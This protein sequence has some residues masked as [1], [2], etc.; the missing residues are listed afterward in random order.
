MKKIVPLILCFFCSFSAFTQTTVPAGAVSGTWTPA[1][2]PYLIQG[3]ITIP[4]GNVLTIQPGVTVSFQ[5]NF[6]LQ[7]SGRL[8]AVGNG[9][10]S[11]RFT[12]ANTATGWQGIRFD[13]VA[14]ANDSSR[15]AFA[16]IQHGLA[17]L[18]NGAGIYINNSQKI[19][20]Y[21]S[22]IS[23]CTAQAGYGGGIYIASSNCVIRNNTISYNHSYSGGLHIQNANPLVDGNAISYNDDI[24]PSFIGDPGSDPDV[25]A[26]GVYCENS[27][28][29]I[30]NNTITNNI[31]S[32]FGGG[33]TAK[34]SLG[35]LKIIH[36]AISY[37][38]APG[39]GGG[40]FSS[41]YTEIR[42]NVI[43][44][45]QG[46]GISSDG[47][48]LITNNYIGFN[49]GKAVG[50]GITI[51]QSGFTLQP[52]VIDHN[53]IVNNIATNSAGGVYI[54]GTKIFVT[55]NLIANNTV[56]GASSPGNT[57]GG[58][59]MIVINSDSSSLLSNNIISNNTA[60]FGG[61]IRFYNSTTKVYSNTICNNSAENGGG[62][63]FDNSSPT[64][65][66]SLVWGNTA[67]VAGNQ[68]SF[69]DEASDPPVSYS[70]IQG[71]TTAFDTGFF[72]YSGTYQD[73]IDADPLFVSAS[74][75]A[76][77]A[78]DGA[79]ANWAL[80]NG[81]PAINKGKPGVGY[82]ATD[83]AGNTRVLNGIIDMGAL[84]NQTPI[85]PTATVSGGGQVCA[86]G[87]LPAVVF[88]FTYGTFP[89]TL[90]YS[91]NGVAQTPVTGINDLQYTIPHASPGLYT[92]TSITDPFST[93]SGIG[94]ATVTVVQPLAGFNIND[95][96]QC[97]PGN[98]F[99]FS[100]TSITN[101][102]TLIYLWNF[103]DASSI[104]NNANPIHVY[105]AAGIYTVKLVVTGNAG[106]RDSV[107]K[108]VAVTSFSINT[109]ADTLKTYQDSVLLNA[110][111]GFSSY[112]W[113][114]G[115]T[116][117]NIKVK[118]SGWYI[119]TVANADGCYAKDSSYVNFRK[120][121]TLFADA[122]QNLCSI[123]SVDLS[124]RTKNITN[125][126]GMQG[127]I[128]WNTSIIKLDSVVYENSALNFS[129]NDINLTNKASGYITYSWSDNTLTGRSVAD[130]TGIFTL[131]FSK[132]NTGAAVTT[133]VTFNSTHTTLEIDTIN[134][135]THTPVIATETAY[136]NGSAAFR[137]GAGNISTN[138]SA[139]DSVVY[140]NRVYYD[141]TVVVDSIKYSGSQCDSLYKTVFINIFDSVRPAISITASA[142]NITYGYPVSFTASTVFGGSS[143][144]IQW[145]K[146]GIALPGQNTLSYSSST[147]N[148]G[149]TIYAVLKSSYS[150]A[151]VDS[152]ISNKIG[153][154]VNYLVS[155]SVTNP[156]GTGIR[157][158]TINI[159]GYVNQGFQT[160]NSGSWE[161][162]LP[163]GIARN[164]V[165]RISKNNDINRT[166]GVSTLDVAMIQSHILN[167]VSF[168]SPYQWIAADVNRS[169]TVTSIDILLIKRFILGLDNSFPGNRQWGFVDTANGSLN[170]LQPLPYKDSII[171][172]GLL[173]TKP[174]QNFTGVKLGDVNFDWNP[175]VSRP[176][177]PVT[178]PVTFYYTDIKVN[179]GEEIRIPVRVKNFR[180][181]LGM[182]F[183][184]NFNSDVLQLQRIE[185][186]LL[187]IQYATHSIHEGKLP[188]IW[189]D[190][191]NKLSSLNDDA[192][193]M[194][195]VFTQKAT[196]TEEDIV[197]TSDIAA[198]ELW[199]G[200][201][202]RHAIVKG[203]GK[204]I[205]A[206]SNTPDFTSESWTVTP[207]P[208]HGM[209]QV[210]LQLL[211]EKDIRI[212]LLDAA[213]KTVLI[214][215]NRLPAGNS[216]IRINLEK[217][218]P[219]A[220][221]SYYMEISG[222]EGNRVKKIMLVK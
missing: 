47:Y 42:D 219:L 173:A 112:L 156:A 121:K 94:S 3:N 17:R 169:N 36:N 81:S 131:K 106:C 197:V 113:N 52:S 21:N 45:N 84:E 107:T 122:K 168:N 73:N 96:S 179:A 88:T 125:V 53:T 133:P 117:Q 29:T 56:T 15:I 83:Q 177:N 209:V 31:S 114:T 130:S 61:G 93:G 152:V 148:A 76:G 188:F 214:Q 6:K 167:A 127:T 67:S 184:L 151:P 210:N 119:V 118:S 9:T 135:V 101:S 46:G 89:F 150:C 105:T 30:S 87:V 57:E 64:I 154:T 69:Y 70:N 43:T 204:I 109:L 176:A 80:Q 26:G 19:A 187:N 35:M 63:F 140:N 203:T 128:S 164:Y 136:I 78:F 40:V 90:Q 39:E 158:P 116:T 37:N 91:I 143:P 48:I 65:Q 162:Y 213:G 7:V 100:N 49:S 144:L 147:L 146:N 4:N 142:Y 18:M 166:N 137:Q 20:V 217:T 132:P 13:N 82:P 27:G 25:F 99:Q 2:S 111:S 178:E 198:V 22:S 221:G 175:L 12:A 159:T 41:G 174:G 185:N 98:N 103:G 201:Y 205:K 190:D 206:G 139:C 10:D 115:D 32:M 141:S 75:G 189:N 14:A 95:N 155:G 200:N 160:G 126:I 181:V 186:N 11:I 180:N 38:S 192:V 60:A 171:I 194:E 207:N 145:Y 51:Y 208:S 215:N 44:Y 74:A 216:S 55:N 92:V 212:K 170:P 161:Y 5:G 153:V 120:N 85:P 66:N 97:L 202:N 8:Q 23:N 50:A 59:G 86:G 54:E 157:Y 163:G 183:T 123:S 191:R 33:I 199:D 193:L 218:N 104:S 129:A 211:K 34:G 58:G 71:G 77:T 28:A 72:S 222:I 134:L 138:L 16:S 68:C 1:G 110:G 196:F 172:N 102:G 149:D 182:Q 220:A 165:I 124:V 24:Y 195:M 79:A 62:I 108:N